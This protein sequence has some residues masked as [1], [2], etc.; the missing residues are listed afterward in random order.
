MVGKNQQKEIK[1]ATKWKL[2]WLKLHPELQRLIQKD[3]TN[4]YLPESTTWSLNL[5]HSYRFTFFFQV[6]LFPGRAD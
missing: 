1:T 2:K 5:I 6:E 4:P 3:R